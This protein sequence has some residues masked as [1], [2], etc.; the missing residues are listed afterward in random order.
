MATKIYCNG[1]SLS[2]DG[3][4]SVWIH[5]T[6]EKID[7]NNVVTTKTKIVS[8]PCDKI[9]KHYVKDERG[10]KVM[11]DDGNFRY[12]IEKINCF[13]NGTFTGTFISEAAEAVIEE[14]LP[15]RMKKIKEL[16]RQIHLIKKALKAAEENPIV[17][18]AV[19]DALQENLDDFEPMTPKEIAA[20]EL[21]C[22]VRN[23]LSR[24]GREAMDKEDDEKETD[25]EP[26]ANNDENDND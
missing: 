20:W 6:K 13:H 18:P 23:T 15:N 12:T 5:I 4:K 19:R 9:V 10:F 7:D 11:G 24:F 3:M 14:V 26:E 21:S 8:I 16:K 2:P 25:V 17:F 22:S 1:V